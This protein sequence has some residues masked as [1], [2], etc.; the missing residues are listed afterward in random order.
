[1][2]RNVYDFDGTIYPSQ[3]CVDFYFY[4]LNKN[5]NIFM[6]LITGAKLFFFGMIAH[7]LGHKKFRINNKLCTFLRYLPNLDQLLTE[8]WKRNRGKIEWYSEQRKETDVIISISPR[9]LIEPACKILGVKNLICTEVDTKSYNIIGRGIDC[10][11]KRIVGPVCS[12]TEK[13]TRFRMNFPDDSF[14][15]FYTDSYR[16]QPLIDLSE[17][18]FLRDKKETSVKN[19]EFKKIK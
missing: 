19:P 17:N 16:D 7:E 14:A 2:K 1:M 4:C 10:T 3:S 5:S 18:A 13:A 9:F 12:G 8:F 6:Y 15:N 11:K